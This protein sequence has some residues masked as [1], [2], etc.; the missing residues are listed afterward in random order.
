MHCK[1]RTE[2]RRVYQMHGKGLS[3]AR[4]GLEEGWLGAIKCT[5]RVYQTHGKSWGAG[6]GSI[7]HTVRVYQTLA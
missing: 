5:V 2:L 3:N 6:G 1:I 7:K 4:L